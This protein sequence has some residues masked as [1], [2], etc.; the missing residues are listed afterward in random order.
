MVLGKRAD[1]SLNVVTIFPSP[2]TT[3]A[4]MQVDNSGQ[5]DLVEPVFMKGTTAIRMDQVS[6]NLSW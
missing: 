6:M 4:T 2:D 3:Q 5:V 1:G